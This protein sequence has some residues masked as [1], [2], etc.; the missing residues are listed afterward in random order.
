VILTAA[1]LICGVLALGIAIGG[2]MFV[3][4]L[5]LQHYYSFLS[6]VPFL[7]E[8]AWTTQTSFLLVAVPLYILLGEIMLRSGIADRMYV[9]LTH[10]V[11]W[12]PGGLMH[13][14]IGA[15]SIFG[16]VSGSSVATAATIGTV[17]IDQID[18]HGYNERLFLGTIAAGGTLGILIPPSIN[19]IVYGAM[20]GT[21]IP[22]LY[23]AG[24]LPGLVLA[25]IFSA[26]VLAAC[27]AK[28]A[29]GGRALRSS[30][31]ERR[32]SLPDLIPPL[33]IILAILGS[34]YLGWATPTESAALG[35]IMALLLAAWNRSLTLTSLRDIL[36]GTMRTTGLVTLIVLGAFYLSYVIAAIGLS[37]RMSALVLDS[38]LGPTGTL[39][40]VVLLYLLLGMFMESLSMMV[41][42]VS[43]VTPVMAALGFDLVWFGVLMMVVMEMALIT[44]PV[45]ANL[46]VVHGIRGRGSINDV[47]VGSAPFVLSMLAMI[48]LLIVFPQI[49]LIAPQL[50]K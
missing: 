27:L 30:W 18:R 26:T 37:D 9:A 24:F 36:E 32:R 16:A 49:A 48:V 31:A 34:I 1:L 21:S 29:W 28:P 20:T 13:S 25:A 47:V 3:I 19:M 46:F 45:G 40:L 11:G 22:S 35:V 38:G 6:L 39:M 12:L 4:A 43:I 23:L 15:C 17:A 41:A 5:V 33:T 14:N 8:S 50:L 10:W 44:P 42:T 2:G 7:G